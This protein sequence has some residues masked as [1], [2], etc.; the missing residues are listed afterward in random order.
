M[1]NFHF[2]YQN[3]H[4]LILFASAFLNLFYNLNIF[5]KYYFL[6]VSHYF[7]INLQSKIIGHLHNFDNFNPKVN[8]TKFI[9]VKVYLDGIIEAAIQKWK[10]YIKS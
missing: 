7:E 2:N 6:I 5:A 4:F 10:I 1:Y 9:S 8:F 3:F